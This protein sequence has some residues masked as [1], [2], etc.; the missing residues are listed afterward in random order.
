MHKFGSKR[1][2]YIINKISRAIITQP[3]VIPNRMKIEVN[4]GVQIYLRNL[5]IQSSS[6]NQVSHK[7][8][9]N[10]KNLLLRTKFYASHYSIN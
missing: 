9:V 3:A 2:A 1:Y 7:L 10:K 5:N 8:N 4:L 6:F